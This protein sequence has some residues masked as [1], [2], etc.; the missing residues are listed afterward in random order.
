MP[1]TSRRHRNSKTVSARSI[2]RP[3]RAAKTAALLPQSLPINWIRPLAEP[4]LRG[5]RPK[6]ECA[7]G[8]RGFSFSLNARRGNGALGFFVGFLAKVGA[9]PHLK[10]ATPECLVFAYVEPVGG[11]LHRAQLHHANGALRWTSGY[12]GWLT[13]RQP[14]FELYE[15]ER[16]ALIRHTTMR[17][18]PADKIQHLGGNFFTETLAWLVRSG[19]VRR[20]R[21]LSAIDANQKN[22][23]KS[24]IR[25]RIP[26]KLGNLNAKH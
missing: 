23:K 3:V 26:H 22:Q 16:T 9:Y 24:S 12:I 25:L 21:E 20:W 6:P 8:L 18:W 14:R 10:P 5:Y 19:L 1:T 11:S 15:S 7:N 2:R 17:A 4:Y 13:H